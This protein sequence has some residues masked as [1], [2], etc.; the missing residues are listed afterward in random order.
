M[1]GYVLVSLVDSADERAALDRLSELDSVEDAHMVF[2]EWDIVL[3]AKAATPEQL[4]AFVLDN[5][6]SRAEVKMTSTLIVCSDQR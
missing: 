2:G 1:L 5:V 3:K 4:S 6:R